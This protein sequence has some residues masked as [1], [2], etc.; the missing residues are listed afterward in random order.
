MKDQTVRATVSATFYDDHCSR[1]LLA[2]TVVREMKTLTVVDLNEEQFVDLLE[3][4]RYYADCMVGFSDGDSYVRTLASSA[5]RVVKE[6]N[7]VV[8]PW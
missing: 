5:R 4:A 7:A 8:V 2:G 1:D 3:D 6:L